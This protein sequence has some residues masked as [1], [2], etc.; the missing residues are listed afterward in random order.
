MS[1]PEY[2]RLSANYV[3]VNLFVVKLTLNFQSSLRLGFAQFRQTLFVTGPFT[4]LYTPKK[5]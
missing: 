5:T 1:V 4:S 2:L 3:G